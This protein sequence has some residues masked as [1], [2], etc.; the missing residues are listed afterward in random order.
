MAPSPSKL[1]VLGEEGEK[2]G[3]Q[4]PRRDCKRS[5]HSSSDG[6]E[7]E[8]ESIPQPEQKAQR[9]RMGRSASPLAR[10]ASF[11]T[12]FC[13][14]DEGIRD[15][16]LRSINS[17]KNEKR[18]LLEIT[19]DSLD[20]VIDRTLDILSGIIALLPDW[21]REWFHMRIF[22]TFKDRTLRSTLPLFVVGSL[23]TILYTGF[24]NVY[25]PGA[26][27]AI[28]SPISIAF[29]SCLA[30][31]LTSYYKG[32]VI[33][34]GQIPD[35]WAEL[36]EVAGRFVERKKSSGDHRFCQKEN[37]Y[38]PD[39]AHF[40]SA[41]NRNVLRMDHYCPWLINCIGCFNYKYFF[42]FLL[43]TTA[44]SNM[45]TFS[46][47]KLLFTEWLSAGHT[48][49]G[50]EVFCMSGLLT[51]VITPFF[52]FHC[53]L[54]S[55]NMTTIEFC[56]TRR[57]NSSGE[58]PY[59]INWYRNIKYALGSNP[60]LWLLPVEREPEHDGLYFEI[61]EELVVTERD[62]EATGPRQTNSWWDEVWVDFTGAC[63]EGSSMTLDFGLRFYRLCLGES[64][65][66]K[67]VV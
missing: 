16:L 22:E 42:L 13:G 19:D 64:D 4:F 5:S 41:M 3:P 8:R 10:K 66:S 7:I 21:F 20:V 2:D 27:L 34:P 36:P 6:S 52:L 25:L 37:R 1:N 28:T 15:L 29:H 39:R 40:C 50:W 47:G 65:Q 55:K 58:S 33:D 61:N 24:V 63:C 11:A 46:L 43:Y 44:A 23:I 59:D 38:K 53:R 32:V 49:F 57:E 67:Q 51:S 31:T 56:E 9:L 62:P 18:N 35:S 17:I 60:L 30:L 45:V 14:N 54:I 12:D 48:F 26:G